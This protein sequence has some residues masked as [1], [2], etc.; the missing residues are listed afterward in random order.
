MSAVT[1]SNTSLLA[2]ATCWVHQG[3]GKC[4]LMCAMCIIDSLGTCVALVPR[5]SRQNDS[6]ETNLSPQRRWSAVPPSKMS[7]L[8]CTA[9]SVHQVVG[10]WQPMRATVI[11]DSLGTCVALVPRESRQNDLTETN[12]SPQRRLSAVPPAKTSLLA[13]ATCRRHRVVG[14]W[15]PLRAM[16]IID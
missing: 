11:I 9:C 7:L 3:A 14:N 2:R 4:Q 15:Q 12:L 5:E 8:A 6:T 13:C 10:N 16:L 1:P